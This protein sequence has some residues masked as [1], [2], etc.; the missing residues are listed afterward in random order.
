MRV[1]YEDLPVDVIAEICPGN[2]FLNQNHT[3]KRFKAQ[4]RS[5]DS[6]IHPAILGWI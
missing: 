5:V 3:V 1:G 4:S 6:N 2:S